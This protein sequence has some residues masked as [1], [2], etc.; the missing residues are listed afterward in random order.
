MK[1]KYILFSTLLFLCTALHG[2]SG[3]ESDLDS[4]SW[5]D[6]LL[7]LDEADIKFSW[8]T[9]KPRNPFKQTRHYFSHQYLIHGCFEYTPAPFPRGILR[10]EDF[11]YWEYKFGDLSINGGLDTR[12]EFQQLHSAGEQ[13]PLFYQ[14]TML[15]LRAHYKGFILFG[16]LKSGLLAGTA[17]YDFSDRELLDI[18]QLFLEKH[19]S[20]PDMRL[21]LGRQE[22]WYGTA[23]L[24]GVRDGS[25]VRRTFDGVQL[26]YEGQYTETDF[27]LLAHTPHRFNAFDNHFS[28]AR[29]LWGAYHVRSILQDGGYKYRSEFYYLGARNRHT[30][31]NEKQ[32]RELRH[33]I[34][35]RFSSHTRLDFSHEAT[36][37]FGKFGKAPIR[38]WSVA[39]TMTYPL[40]LK[41]YNHTL[42]IE[43]SLSS[44]ARGEQ[45]TGFSP[46][47]PEAGYFGMW[48]W[49]G[50]ANATQ[51]KLFFESE[52]F[53]RKYRK[54]LKVRPS[55]EGFWRTS[56]QD[57]VY[58]PEGMLL[59]AN[60]DAKN[61]FVGLQAGAVM[62]IWLGRHG[63]LGASY[64]YFKPG[65]VALEEQQ[66]W[67]VFLK[68]TF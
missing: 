65:D 45:I 30:V 38:A 18:H 29:T 62:E 22:L 64:F 48:K 54:V 43:A 63:T 15:H 68:T 20:W 19:W 14:R 60:E 33:S 36:F 16:Q 21:R 57:G 8:Q 4:L 6:S 66:R 17:Q 34:G 61:A 39:S 37:Q 51:T 59:V 26:R 32:A 2:V 27:L 10:G 28:L 31:W 52:F 23:R 5:Q 7:L 1:I 56:L 44:G 3:Q 12:S 58:A 53:T 35:G 46:L 11:T 42:G 47:Y 40:L 49:I 25:N 55:V 13:Q 9:A 67:G 24:I 41:E 50:G